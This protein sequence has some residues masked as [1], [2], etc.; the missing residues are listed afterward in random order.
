MRTDLGLNTSMSACSL[1][2]ESS[3]SVTLEQLLPTFKGKV[4]RPGSQPFGCDTGKVQNTRGGHFD[5]LACPHGG[6]AEP[7]AR[8]SHLFGARLDI[9]RLRTLKH[10]NRPTL[11]TRSAQASRDMTVLDRST[12]HVALDAAKLD[13]VHHVQIGG[14]AERRRE[15]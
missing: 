6:H 12:V 8:A 10:S 4:F 7:Q 15:G 13:R 1:K 9:D 14:F 5:R 11:R 2:C 3:T